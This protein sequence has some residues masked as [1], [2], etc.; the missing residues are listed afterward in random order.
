[1]IC[2]SLASHMQSMCSNLVSFLRTDDITTFM[3]LCVCDWER[4]R[5]K[6]IKKKETERKTCILKINSACLSVYSLVIKMAWNAC[7]HCY[8]QHIV[9][10]QFREAARL[11]LFNIFNQV[12]LDEHSTTLGPLTV[13]LCSTVLKFWSLVFSRSSS[14]GYAL[15][16]Y[17]VWALKNGI[18]EN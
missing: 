14:P 5:V 4:E 18:R 15:P 12:Q 7:P 9:L 3:D 10:A 16:C 11:H 17:P 2:G 13:Q 6:E 8:A 1:M